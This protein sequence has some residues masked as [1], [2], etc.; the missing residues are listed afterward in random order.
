MSRFVALAMVSV[1]LM[2]PIASAHGADTFSFIMRSS[3]VQPDGA[4]VTANDTLVFYNVVG[5]NRTLSS[6]LNGNGTE[7]WTCDAGPSDSTN[8]E[9]EC[10]LWLDPSAGEYGS[11]EIDIFN[12][13]SE[14]WHSIVV[15]VLSDNHTENG[16]PDG[17]FVLP[18]RGGEAANPTEDAGGVESILLSGAILAYGA[19]ACIWIMR[20]IGGDESNPDESTPGESDLDESNPDESNPDVPNSKPEGEE[21]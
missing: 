10:H 5:W 4:T 12:N 14:L 20:N 9:D 7:D 2:G 11:I 21:K 19:A 13:G 18:G 6:D 17:G 8:T 16:P 15:E 3:S 1:L